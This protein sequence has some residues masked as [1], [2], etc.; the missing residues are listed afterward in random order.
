MHTVDTPLIVN[1]E[2]FVP[3]LFYLGAF[4]LCIPL[5]VGADTY[6]LDSEIHSDIF[7]WRF[8]VRVLG[9]C[10]SPPSRMDEGRSQVTVTWD[11]KFIHA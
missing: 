10:F 3:I 5:S 11:A 8:Q 7:W 6:C 1:P 4:C 9:L 2:S